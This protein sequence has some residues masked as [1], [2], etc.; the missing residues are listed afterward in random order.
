MEAAADLAQFPPDGLLIGAHRAAV[1]PEHDVE[2]DRL[3]TAAHRDGDAVT[4]LARADRRAERVG[5]FDVLFAELDDDV[6]AADACRSGG[7]MLDG[8]VD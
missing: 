4:W 7:P 2:G 1:G 8:L 5:V 3:L 6:A